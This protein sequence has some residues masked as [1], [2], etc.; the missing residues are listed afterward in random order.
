MKEEKYETKVE[1]YIDVVS[2]KKLSRE[3]YYSNGN[4]RSEYYSLNGRW[5][6]EDGS[7]VILYHESGKVKE[8]FYYL[9][10]K[11]H[12]KNGPSIIDYDNGGKIRTEYYYLNDIK[13]DV[14]QEMVIQGLKKEEAEKLERKK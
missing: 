10:G 13:C 7:S 3:I 14:L 11:L 6:R 9:N 8:E 1:K 4:I 5:H 12:R 2:N